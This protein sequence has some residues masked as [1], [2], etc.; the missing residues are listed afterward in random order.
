MSTT[1]KPS[2]TPPGWLRLRQWLG[3]LSPREQRGVRLAAWVLGLA[4]LWWV[5]LA[6]AID[7]LR[8]AQAEHERLDRTLGLMQRQ[9]SAAAQLRGSG[10]TPTP[11]REQAVRALEEATLALGTG[12]QLAWQGERA[13]VTLR[14]VPPQ[15]LAQWLTQ[16][17][18][19]ARLLPVQARLQRGGSP[20][21][22]SG[23]IVLAGP[24]L[25]TGN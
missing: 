5:G 12:A 16:V 7:T 8:R 2:R 18:V 25:G 24:G 19:N 9:A 15:R 4:L 23:Q 3:A 14:G 10:A 11:A 22:W 1:P 21:G 20:E 13:S 17:R 6:P